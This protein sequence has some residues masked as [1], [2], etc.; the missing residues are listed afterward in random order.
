MPAAAVLHASP[1]WL[2]LVSPSPPVEGAPRPEQHPPR[3]STAPPQVATA[4]MV[5]DVLK[6]AWGKFEAAER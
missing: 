1:A 5:F 6:A 2:V 4:D 3:T